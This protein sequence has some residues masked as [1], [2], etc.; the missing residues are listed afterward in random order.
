M[1]ETATKKPEVKQEQKPEAKKKEK[2]MLKDEERQRCDV[3]SRVMGYFSAVML[4]DGNSMWNIGKRQEF[5]DREYFK[6]PKKEEM[7]NLE[8]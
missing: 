5:A 7:E 3:Y 8:K 4:R 6:E 1:P 2:I